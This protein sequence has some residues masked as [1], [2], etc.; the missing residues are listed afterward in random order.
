MGNY[1]FKPDSILEFH[2]PGIGTSSV[3]SKAV[4]YFNTYLSLANIS[5]D[6]KGFLDSSQFM[7]NHGATSTVTNN[8]KQQYSDKY[9]QKIN[10]S[11][12]NMY[13]GF[14]YNNYSSI[15]Y[16]GYVT[17]PFK[18][19]GKNIKIVLPGTLIHL[20]NLLR[21]ASSGSGSIERTPQTLYSTHN[22]ST[23]SRH[24]IDFPNSVIPLFTAACVTG[25]GGGGSSS[26]MTYAGRGGGGGG[27]ACGILSFIDGT[28]TSVTYSYTVGSGGAGG[29]HVN[30]QGL[31]QDNHDGKNGSPSYISYSGNTVLYGGY[32]NGGEAGE[33]TQA[34]SGGYTCNAPY[35]MYLYGSSTTYSGTDGGHGSK[36]TNSEASSINC[37]KITTTP[38]SSTFTSSLYKDVAR[39]PGVSYQP[40]GAGGGASFRSNGAIGGNTADA[41][42]SADSGSGAGGGGGGYY[43]GKHILG[44]AGGSGYVEFYL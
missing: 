3:Q 29:T 40:G 31:Q 26:E 5:P 25:G 19:E 28:K 17:L 2:C 21:G 9:K 7:V 38:Y 23:I 30:G 27:F 37:K 20:S 11:V 39:H 1:K 43:V 4:S 18:V 6:K 15:P 16:L 14:L 8:L 10:D 32:G 42:A 12:V 44:G 24:S 33:G 35:S 36:D 34:P 22:G 41:G 13:N